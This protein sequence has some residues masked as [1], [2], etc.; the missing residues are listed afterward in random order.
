M[1]VSNLL[2]FRWLGWE[3]IREAAPHT[4]VG[5]SLYHVL[6]C[7]AGE[8]IYTL[9]GTSRDSGDSGYSETGFSSSAKKVTG[10]SGSGSGKQH[11]T[12]YGGCLLFLLTAKCVGYIVSA[13]FAIHSQDVVLRWTA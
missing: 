3:F 6:W 7:A 8:P 4:L 5:R 1:L 2:E 12:G 13:P 9:T 11:F 10:R